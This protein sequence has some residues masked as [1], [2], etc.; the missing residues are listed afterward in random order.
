VAQTITFQ[1]FRANLRA[2]TVA[3][4][5]GDQLGELVV[6]STAIGGMDTVA[7]VKA[8]VLPRLVTTLESDARVTLVFDKRAMRD[9]SLF[10]AD[11]FMMLPAWVQ[12]VIHEGSF[13]DVV[14]AADRLR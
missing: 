3:E 11:H 8:T 1:L 4:L 12:V 14:A 9:D 13:D 10:Y 5:Q 6:D 2:T 7:M